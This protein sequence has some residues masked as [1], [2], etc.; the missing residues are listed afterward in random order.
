M[1]LDTSASPP[2]TRITSIPPPPYTTQA[3]RVSQR[4]F[5][6]RFKAAAAGIQ[7]SAPALALTVVSGAFS[8]G[9]TVVRYSMS[10]NMPAPFTLILCPPPSPHP[11]P[12]PTHRP[13]QPDKGPSH[14]DLQAAAAGHKR[15]AL[16]AVRRAGSLA[17]YCPLLPTE[18]S[19]TCFLTLL[20]APPP[21][22]HTSPPTPPFH[23]PTQPHPLPHT[24]ARP[25]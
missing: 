25:A 9:S 17:K 24:Q 7:R 20:Q 2:P 21:P 10:L 22:P 19:G 12:H 23:T 3:T 11:P 14:S 16:T 5:P 4:T 1:L 13:D 8:L 6:P 15:F 18:C